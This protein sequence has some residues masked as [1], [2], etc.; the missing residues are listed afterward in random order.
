VAFSPWLQASAHVPQ[1]AGSVDRSEQVV[2]QVV[3][4]ALQVTSHTPA[5]QT[6]PI[7]QKFPHTPQLSLSVC[8]LVQP[9]PQ[10]A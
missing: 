3:S 7:S 4:G 10:S 9:L 1:F 8:S 6:W 2:P 5:A